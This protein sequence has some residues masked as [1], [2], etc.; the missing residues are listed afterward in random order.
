M[1][2]KYDFIFL[3]LCVFIIH[4]TEKLGNVLI[5]INMLDIQETENYI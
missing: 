3:I 1:A 2:Q 5:C 4:L